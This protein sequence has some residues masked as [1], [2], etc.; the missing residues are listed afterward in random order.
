MWRRFSLLSTALPLL[1]FI[2]VVERSPRPALFAGF[3]P[4]MDAE[5][6][7]L[8]LLTMAEWVDF[9]RT[10]HPFRNGK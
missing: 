1:G 4:E 6:N 10:C 5:K 7:K 2:S 3:L 9:W 8:T